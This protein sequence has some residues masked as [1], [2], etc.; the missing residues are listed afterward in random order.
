[1]LNNNDRLYV[2]T[3]TYQV[4]QA[5]EDNRTTPTSLPYINYN[6]GSKNLKK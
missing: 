5:N 2:N 3:T 4:V 1:M 6:G